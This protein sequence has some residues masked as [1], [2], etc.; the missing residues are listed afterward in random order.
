VDWCESAISPLASKRDKTGARFVTLVF[1]RTSYGTVEG[2]FCEVSFTSVALSRLRLQRCSAT[3]SE[4]SNLVFSQVSA[5]NHAAV[6]GLWGK[7]GSGRN[8]TLLALLF[9][10]GEFPS[11][12]F[13]LVYSCRHY[14]RGIPD[15]LLDNGF[16][17]RPER[18]A[19]VPC[20]NGTIR[21]ALLRSEKFRYSGR[22]GRRL[23]D[24]NL[25]TV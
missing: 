4:A 20:L 9:P 19:Q 18:G 25:I 7:K 23:A 12:V 10:S 3:C 8:A 16:V 21:I 17:R 11:I 2:W 14:T 24:T 1:I 6:A 22:R 15:L 5:R 13:S